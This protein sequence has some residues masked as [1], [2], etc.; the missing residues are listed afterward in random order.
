[1]IMIVLLIVVHANLREGGRKHF[2]LESMQVPKQR[3]GGLF[4]QT[5]WKQNNTT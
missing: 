4:L 3:P 5:T 1:M 2:L